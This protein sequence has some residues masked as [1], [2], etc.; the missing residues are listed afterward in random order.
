VAGF[1]GRSVVL[2]DPTPVDP[3]CFAAFPAVLAARK[4]AGFHRE[5][6]DTHSTHWVGSRLRPFKV[7]RR[8]LS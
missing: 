1:P 8:G 2:G 5:V 4:T 6:N 7:K 3:G